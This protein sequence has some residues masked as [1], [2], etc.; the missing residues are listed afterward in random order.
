MVS[1]KLIDE[2]ITHFFR[3][4]QLIFEIK[5]DLGQC[6]GTKTAF[7]VVTAI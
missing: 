1:L 7:H 2:A 4:N 3:I 6:F 5:G